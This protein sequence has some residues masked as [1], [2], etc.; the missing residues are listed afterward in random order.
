MR[1]VGKWRRLINNLGSG[2]LALAL[3]TIVWI[4][5]VNEENPISEDF[6][7][8]PI[9]IQVVNKADD[10]YLFGNIEG[11]TVRVRI[12]A[13]RTSWDSLTAAK[14]EAKLDLTGLPP[15]R[16][17]LPIEVTCA[18]RAVR[19]IEVSPATMLV[20][21]EP[22]ISRQ[23]P[24][25]INV[26]GAPALG[27]SRR[28]QE[29]TPE[30]VKVSGPESMVQQVE[31]ASAEIYLRGSEK[32]TLEREVHLS[33]RDANGDPVGWVKLEPPT[34]SVR[35]P[36]EQQHGFKEVAVRAVITGQVRSGYW[37]SSVSVEPTTVT[38][39]GSPAALKQIP[40]YVETTAIDVSGAEESISQRVPLALPNGVA[41]LGEQ[42]V[43]VKVNV[44]AIQGGLTVQ[45]ELVIQGL[46][47]GY[48]ARPSPDTVDVILSGPLPKLEA[49]RQGDVVVILNLFGLEE[50]THQVTPKVLAPED[51]VVESVLPATIE[52]LIARGALPTFTPTPVVTPTPTATPTP[53]Q[54]TP[55]VVPTPTPLPTPNCPHPLAHLTAP[56][57]GATVQGEVELYGTA[58]IANFDYYKIEFRSDEATEWAFIARYD[59]PVTDGLL[60]V[61]DTSNLPAGRYW[62]R[63]V[64]VDV[65]GNY[66]DPCAVPVQV[67]H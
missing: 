57:V 59:Q 9:P 28:T 39:I 20:R 27:Y 64:V 5:A 53:A 50:G 36:I 11:E 33:A 60:A 35:I 4:V 12:R 41:V 66:F 55:T 56:L 40:G 25:E 38:I 61:W 17:D 32:E 67:V 48:Q 44:T 24:V 47:D 45:R 2:I 37:V 63:L 58:A 51:I 18:D 65:I 52:V 14:F 31:R 22:I 21:L 46:E 7:Q 19:I 29:V 16:H 26:L 8:E 30:Q 43:T 1:T 54:P 42:A 3:A 62:V 6:F 10:L 13:P 15:G 23:V 34:A 49:L